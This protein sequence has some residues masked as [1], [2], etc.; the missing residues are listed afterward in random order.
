MTKMTEFFNFE[1]NVCN[2][3]P[4]CE[5]LYTRCRLS[6]FAFPRD[7]FH[8]GDYYAHI[9]LIGLSEALYYDD[10]VL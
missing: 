10:H 2:W 4:V 1:R 3:K 5:H 7:L 6:F 9:A 8:K